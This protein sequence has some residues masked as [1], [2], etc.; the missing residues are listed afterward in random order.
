MPSQLDKLLAAAESGQTGRS[1]LI[2]LVPELAEQVEPGV[3]PEAAAAMTE[4]RAAGAKPA[5]QKML[6]EGSLM[7]AG[8]F[9]GGMAGGAR[10]IPQMLG[11]A[12]GTFAGGTLAGMPPEEALKAAALSSTVGGAVG[13]ATRLATRAA[14]KMAGIES[15]TVKAGM[16][17][18]SLLN[19][20]QKEVSVTERFGKPRVKRVTSTEPELELANRLKASTDIKAAETTQY[21]EIYQKALASV[22]NKRIDATPVIDAFAKR[23]TRADHPILRAADRQVEAMGDRF[24]NRVGPDGR[25]SIADLDA[26]IRENFTDPLSGAYARGSEAET[27]RRLMEIR[28]DLTKHLYGAIGP[29]AAPTQAFTQR[30]LAKREAVENVFGTGTPAKPSS[31]GAEA[32]RTIRSQSGGA[33]R[34]R[35]ILR[36]YDEEYGTDF[37]RQAEQLSMQREWSGDTLAT[38]YAIDSVLQPSRPSF[39]RGIARPV[40][41]FGARISV[42]SGPV[43][44]G[45]TAA[46]Q[47][48]KK[49]RKRIS[50]PTP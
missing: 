48:S 4:L 7:G 12:A 32:I 33:Q 5:Q 45:A 15:S 18:P 22:S 31:A 23:I 49:K 39:V 16:R 19:M 30:A 24:L 43:A 46:A 28:G 35:E 27:V 13:G 29:V 50:L 21:H 9:L 42:P 25:I 26:Y 1:R 3:P 34:N 37:L 2:E 17:D 38:A 36:A 41:R 20:P 14:G 8:G 40:A 44:A 47:A 10:L 6:L 11:E